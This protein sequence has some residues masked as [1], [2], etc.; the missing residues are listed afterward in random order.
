[1]RQTG[2]GCA[3]LAVAPGYRQEL[4]QV[5]HTGLVAVTAGVR[6]LRSGSG[7]SLRGDAMTPYSDRYIFASRFYDMAK[8]TR[9]TLPEGMFAK[10]RLAKTLY[11]TGLQTEEDQALFADEVEALC[12]AYGLP[13]EVTPRP[14]RVYLEYGVGAIGWSADDVTGCLRNRIDAGQFIVKNLETG[15]IVGG[16]EWLA[17]VSWE[18]QES[19]RE[20]QTS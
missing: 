8:K 18:T 3:R 2:D 5:L 19:E 14:Y 13:F 4:D 16:R 7:E 6:I 17:A 15:E 11:L 1:M 9:Y 10:L 12:T 20:R